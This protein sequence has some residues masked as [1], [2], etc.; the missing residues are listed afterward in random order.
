MFN[1]EVMAAIDAAVFLLE[2]EW[3][4]TGAPDRQKIE[5]MATASAQRSD[6][7]WQTQAY[8]RPYS[9]DVAKGDTFVGRFEKVQ[10]L[11]NKMLLLSDGVIYVTGQKRVGKTSLA[12]AAVEFAQNTPPSRE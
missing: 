10:A 11:G 12:L 3:D 1:G 4:E 9:T 6:I 5:F 2:V 7:D 8:R